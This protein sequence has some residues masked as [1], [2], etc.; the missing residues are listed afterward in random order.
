MGYPAPS[1]AKTLFTLI[2]AMN[3]SI[4]E[5]QIYFV[6]WGFFNPLINTDHVETGTLYH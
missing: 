5:E 2:Q 6:L 3:P 1:F 4:N